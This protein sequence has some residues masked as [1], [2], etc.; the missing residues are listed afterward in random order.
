MTVWDVITLH[1]N[2]YRDGST[3]EEEKSTV[4]MWRGF[5]SVQIAK[6][7]NYSAFSFS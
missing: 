6:L 1:A 5:I 2:N 4:Y 3:K 7:R